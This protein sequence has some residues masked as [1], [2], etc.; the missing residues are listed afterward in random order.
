MID[1]DRVRTLKEEV[2]AED[3]DEVLELF[4]AEVDEAMG[5]LPAARDAASLS[6]EMHFLKGAALNLGFEVLSQRCHDGETQATQGRIG[7]IDVAEIV[8]VYALSR[9][10]FMADLPART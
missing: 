7:Q 4:F 6:A 8:R 9:Q 2:G 1:W 10:Q 5:R 3:F